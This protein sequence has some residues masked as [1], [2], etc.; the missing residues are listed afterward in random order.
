M[1]LGKTLSDCLPREYDHAVVH[2][3][4]DFEHFTYGDSV[5]T[6]KGKQISHLIRGH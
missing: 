3:D 5:E 4:P 6:S 1:D 2:F